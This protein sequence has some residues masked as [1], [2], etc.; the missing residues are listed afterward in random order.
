MGRSGGRASLTLAA[1]GDGA[2]I[3]ALGLGDLAIQRLQAALLALRE[4]IGLHILGVLHRDRNVQSKLALDD[5]AH[6]V[7]GLGVD[8]KHHALADKGDLDMQMSLF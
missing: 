3:I 8:Q 7:G 6:D 5:A 4:H 2:V 1:L